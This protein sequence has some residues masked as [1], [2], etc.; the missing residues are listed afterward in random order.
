MT[1]QVTDLAEAIGAELTGLDVNALDDTTMSE[2]MALFYDRM[3]LVFRDQE[4]TPEQ[5]VA[6]ARRFGTVVPYP[7]LEGIP[8]CPEV[9][10]VLT[11]PEDSINF[12]GGWHSDTPYLEKPSLGSVLYAKDLPPSGGDTLF[13]NMYAAYEALDAET[14]ALIETRRAVHSGNK[15]YVQPADRSKIYGQMKK[16]KMDGA[17]KSDSAHPMVRTHPVTGRKSLFVSYLHTVGIEGMDEPEAEALLD[18]LYEH[19]TRPEFT[20]R[21]VWKPGT[22]AIWDNRCVLHNALFDY[23]GYTRRMHRVTVEGERP[24]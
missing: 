22:L 5:Q 17:L 10:E 21:V 20:C 7:F 13:S 11:R 4:I 19:Q 12:G 24:V 2:I 1:M 16:V 8:E 3:V 18:R 15:R 14:K 9:I 6:F 23:E